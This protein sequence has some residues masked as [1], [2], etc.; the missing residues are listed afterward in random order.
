MANPA[1]LQP[2]TY[3]PRRLL[4]E[5]QVLCRIGAAPD[6]ADFLGSNAGERNES[7]AGL[8]NL[9]LEEFLR[10]F[11]HFGLKAAGASVTAFEPFSD[12]PE[13]LHGTDIQAIYWADGRKLRPV[14]GH[15]IQHLPPGVASGA[16]RTEWPGYY[17]VLFDYK[18]SKWRIRWLPTPTMTKP[19]TI[20]FRQQPMVYT[21]GNLDATTPDVVVPVPDANIE[22]LIY[23]VA[24]RIQARNTGSKSLTPEGLREQY[25]ML[26]KKLAY[27]ETP[28]D[29]LVTGTFIPYG[30]QPSNGW[31][32]REA[33]RA[34]S[35]YEGIY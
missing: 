26:R 33:W 18:T 8:L 25:E 24:E 20:V 2:A 32:A 11:P 4:R 6:A 28:L 3:T 35:D 29:D 16:A 13:N 1:M 7:L 19:C 31:E 30:E 15:D 10:D 17:T 12:L 9:S 27:I 5:A 23:L 21:A 14:A 22:P 34:L